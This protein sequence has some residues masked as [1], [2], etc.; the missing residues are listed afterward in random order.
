MEG[1]IISPPYGPVYWYCYYHL[2]GASTIMS[3]YNFYLMN[4]LYILY[5]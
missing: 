5:T 3:E 1:E 2:G 4:I